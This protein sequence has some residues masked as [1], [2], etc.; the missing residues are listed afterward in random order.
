MALIDPLIRLDPP[1]SPATR[2]P[3][4]SCHIA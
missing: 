4:G 3:S 1:P 2:W